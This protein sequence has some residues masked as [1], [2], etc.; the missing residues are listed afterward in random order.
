LKMVKKG[1][2]NQKETDRAIKAAVDQ[3]RKVLK[4]ENTHHSRHR[5]THHV[6]SRQKN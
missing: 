5:R 6:S 1:L 4:Y 2:T 3:A